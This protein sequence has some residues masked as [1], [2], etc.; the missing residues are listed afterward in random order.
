MCGAAAAR[1][2]DLAGVVE[3]GQRA[4]DNARSI[5]V[6]YHACTVPGASEP[7][8][9][10]EPEEM[11]YGVGI[12]GEAGTDRTAKIGAHEL[13]DR[14][15]GDIVDSLGLTADD[16]VICL[17]NGLGSA[18]PLEL[19]LMLGEVVAAL[20][21]RDITVARPMVGTFV[22]ALDMTGVSVT[23]IRTDDEIVELFDAPTTAPGWPGAPASAPASLSDTTFAEPDDAADDGD[24]CG[25]LSDFVARV[26]DSIDDLTDLDQRAGDGDFGHNMRAALE[27][28]DIPLRGSDAEVLTAISTSYLVRAG[29]TSGAIFGVLFR[30]LAAAFADEDDRTTALRVGSASALEEITDLGGAQVG[31]NTVV[32]ALA[33]ASAALDDGADPADAADRA[34][35]GAESTREG[36]ATKGRASYVGD[37]ARGVVD[38]GAL[39]VSWLYRA[40][41]DAW[42]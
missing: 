5:A 32:D 33:P 24:A 28:F 12:H 30:Q 40:A 35:A 7:T 34:E 14:M 9:E 1:G 19:D 16:Q 31:D 6:A 3:V 25:W 17:V 22:T 15:V 42:P 20:G 4:A 29:G 38:P 26:V 18:H 27:H 36:T 37:N 39:V 13:A 23:L 11:E 41:A 8:F 2:D 21:E 10:L